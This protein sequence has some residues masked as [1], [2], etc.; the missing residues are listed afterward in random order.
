[1]R[2]IR[3]PIR[4]SD[5]EHDHHGHDHGHD[6]VPGDFGRAFAVGAVLNTALVI[7]QIIYG[8][9]ANSTA[10]LADAAHNF[11]DVLGLLLAW[12]A[13]LLA[14]RHPTER[15][16]YGFRSTSIFAAL[17]NAV[18][19]LVATGAIALEAIQRFLQPQPVAG[20]TIV[21]V[22]FVGIFVNGLTAWMLTIGRNGDLN[23]R[24]AYLHMLAD[25]GVSA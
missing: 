2:D 24:G 15:F 5:H 11:G 20:L 10:L 25:A 6:H 12:G 3:M 18:I 1:M 7:V 16:T 21:V 22:A 23:V 17:L 13:F 4:N 14:R 9:I 8:I 19:L